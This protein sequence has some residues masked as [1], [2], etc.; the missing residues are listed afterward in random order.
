MILL[1]ASQAVAS[2]FML[3]TLSIISVAVA[4]P[5][6]AQVQGWSAYPQSIISASTPIQ[7]EYVYGVPE[8]MH[9]HVISSSSLSASDSHLG[10]FMGTQHQWTLGENYPSHASS[11]YNDALSQAKNQW[12]A[13]HAYSP[14]YESGWRLLRHDEGVKYQGDWFSEEDSG[15]SNLFPYPIYGMRCN[16]HFCDNKM[17]L[18]VLPNRKA[19]LYPHVST[20]TPWTSDSDAVFGGRKHVAHCPKGQ[21]AVQ[22]QCAGSWCKYIRLGCSTLRSEFRAQYEIGRYD[23]ADSNDSNLNDFFSNE[24]PSEGYCPD[25]EYVDGIE[26]G[27]WF[28]NY[29]RLFCS[30]IQIS[31]RH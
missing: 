29:I 31:T 5:N 3:F 15:F 7:Y 10:G 2:V 24:S 9:P 22:V 18:Y 16:G 25:G 6:T 28:C 26:C 11:F 27:G 20:W 1:F 30:R 13:A 17:A 21:F 23:N 19:P 12:L 14:P 8:H 4:I